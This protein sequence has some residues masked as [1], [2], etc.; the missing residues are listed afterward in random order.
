MDASGFAIVMAVIFAGL[1]G[2]APIAATI[3]QESRC[4]D[5]KIEAQWCDDM[6]GKQ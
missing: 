1:A 3:I 6:K 5:G 4:F 2:I